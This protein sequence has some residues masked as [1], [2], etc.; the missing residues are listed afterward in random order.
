MVMTFPNE[1]LPRASWL[2]L[3]S[4]WASGRDDGRLRGQLVIMMEPTEERER[5]DIATNTRNQ[6]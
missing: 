5:D 4:I 2:P 3:P 1:T 6:A